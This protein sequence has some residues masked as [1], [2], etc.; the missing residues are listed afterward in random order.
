MPE[1]LRTSTRDLDDL[2]LR[3]QTWLRGRTGERSAVS[4]LERP[5]GNGLSSETLFFTARLAPDGR[6]QRCVARLAPAPEAVPVFPSYDLGAQFEVM[7]LAAE[8]V[9]A[10]RPLWFEPDPAHLGVP[11]LVMAR[12]EGL[13]PPDVMPYTFEGW[14][15]EADPADLRRL[16]DRTV[17][18]LAALHT[19]PLSPGRLDFLGPPGLR[20]HVTATR[21]YYDWA[22]GA[23]PVPLLE[24]AFAWLEDHW[25]AEPGPDVLSW[26]DARIGNVMYRDFEPV[27]VLDWEMA[28][29]GPPELD[30]GWMIFLHRFFQD[31][32]EVFGLPGLPDFLTREQVCA[33]YRQASGYEPRDLDFYETYAALRHGVIMARVWHRRIHFGEQAMPDDPDDLVMHRARLEAMLG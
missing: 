32:A 2:R 16:Q 27:A 11:F 18:L 20:A 17:G 3:V 22:H 30:L 28:A 15:L 25:P 33:A 10:P 5:T 12:E 9:P 24:R 23:L 26:G 7:R 14:L 31:V 13:V 6:E 19:A 4:E 8:H 29:C 21:R 1:Q